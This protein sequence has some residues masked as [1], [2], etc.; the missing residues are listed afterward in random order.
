MGYAAATRPVVHPPQPIARRP[1]Q[2][3][4]ARSVRAVACDRART[5]GAALRRAV[6]RQAPGST[7]GAGI[8][9]SFRPQGA[10]RC[11]RCLAVQAATRKCHREPP[12]KPARF[13]GGLAAPRPIGLALSVWSGLLPFVLRKEGPHGCNPHPGITVNPGGNCSIEKC[14]HGIR[15]CLRLGLRQPR[16]V[17]QSVRSRR[18]PR[19]L[20]RRRSRTAGTL[21]S[22][23]RHLPRLPGRS[24]PVLPGGT[25][26]ANGKGAGSLLRAWLID[27]GGRGVQNSLPVKQ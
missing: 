6:A 21:A 10:V 9:T 23:V 14:Y 26:E 3:Q 15:I 24:G 11:D 12:R 7:P 2:A 18:W 25:S 8:G 13:A 16:H 5:T 20:V 4:R 19:Q 17:D 1:G 22:M 27:V